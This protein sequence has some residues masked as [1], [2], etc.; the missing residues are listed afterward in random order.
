MGYPSLGEGAV[1]QVEEIRS[2]RTLVLAFES[3]F[4][5]IS[6]TLFII[7]TGKAVPMTIGIPTEVVTP[8][9]SSVLTALRAGFLVDK[10]AAFMFNIIMAHYLNSS[11]GCYW[12]WKWILLATEMAIESGSRLLAWLVFQPFKGN[13]RPL[14]A[15]EAILLTPSLSC[16]SFGY[17]LARPLEQEPDIEIRVLVTNR[18]HL[19]SVFEGEPSL[20]F[21][22]DSLLRKYPVWKIRS[23]LSYRIRE[24]VWFV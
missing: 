16:E 17:L 18:K 2:Y 15:K 19:L 24:S 9:V 12:V 6:V 5:V 20:G 13:L 23:Y 10:G 21:E 1:R 8:V 14:S 3:P 11:N 22:D 4:V 7:P